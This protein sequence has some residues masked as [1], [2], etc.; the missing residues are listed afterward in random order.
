MQLFYCI[1][2]MFILSATNGENEDCPIYDIDFY[3][4][5]D[6]VKIDHVNSWTECGQLCLNANSPYNYCNYWT[7]QNYGLYQCTLKS[8]NAGRMYVPNVIS[9]AKSCN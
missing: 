9:G 7:W 2:I 3:D 4:G 1:T 5:P 6:I 8:G